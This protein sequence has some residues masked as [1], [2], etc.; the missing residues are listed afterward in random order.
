[1][2][3]ELGYKPVE[4]KFIATTEPGRDGKQIKGFYSTETNTMYIN[5]LNSN[6]NYELLITSGIEAQRAIDAQEGSNF[7]QDDAYRAERSKYSEEFGS[8]IA[9]YTNFALFYTG[10]GS[11]STTTNPTNLYN[12]SI[13][14]NNTEF[15]QLDKTKGAN[16]IVIPIAAEIRW[17]A[18]KGKVSFSDLEQQDEEQNTRIIELTTQ[19]LYEDFNEAVELINEAPGL[20]KELPKVLMFLVDNPEDLEK[21]PGYVQKSVIEFMETFA[22]QI[23]DI[24]D[25]LL[26]NDPVVLEKQAQAESDLIA[27]VSSIFL[28]AGIA[29]ISLVSG[30]VILG[31]ASE[32]TTKIIISNK[33]KNIGNKYN[34]V[35]TPE[36]K[37]KQGEIATDYAT[38]KYN[39]WKKPDGKGGFKDDYPDNTKDLDAIPGTIVST[40]LKKGDILVRYVKKDS[41]PNT[42]GYQLDKDTHGTYTTK[43]GESWESWESLALPGKKED[44]V[45]YKIEV[46]EDIPTKQSLVTPWFDQIGGGIQ[47]KFENSLEN[48]A[49]PITG[50]KVKLIGEYK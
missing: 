48:L 39:N 23:E 13:T 27:N 14:A 10:Q 5:T 24:K 28:G 7:D 9:G 40:T 32:I 17:L 42:G 20:I 46:L 4:I 26:T 21:F 3:E 18:L 15:S 8:Y 2:L 22:T 30:K 35:S 50:T 47:Y 49:D 25:G 19:K 33:L 1:M 29:K 16:S 36:I 6:T 38:A 11:V 45:G 44:Y 12:K 31:K 43:P 41:K 37:A 34:I